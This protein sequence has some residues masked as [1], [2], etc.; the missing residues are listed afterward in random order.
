MKNKIIYLGFIS[1]FLFACSKEAPAPVA[2]PPVQTPANTMTPSTPMPPATPEP[3]KPT[4]PVKDAPCDK[5]MKFFEEQIWQ[6]IL[7]LQCVGCHNASGTAQSTRLVLNHAD[8]LESYQA[9]KDVALEELAGTSLLLLKPTLLHPQGHVGGQLIA[10]DSGKY[11]ALESFV[12][13]VKTDECD[14]PEEKTDTPCTEVKPGERVLRRLTGREY[15]NTIKDLLGVDSSFG[16]DFVTDLVVNGFNNNAEALVISGLLADQLSEAATSIAQSAV[17]TNIL[18]CTEQTETC[19]RQ[20]MTEFGER[21]YRQPLTTAQLNRHILLYR[22]GSDFEDGI[23]LVITAMLQSPHFLYRSELGTHVADGNYTLSP[24]EIA[25]QLSYFLTE[26]MPDA[27]LMQAARDNEL[28]TQA[29]IEA[30]ARRLL[31][32]QSAQAPIENFIGQWLH[33]DHLKTIPKDAITYPEFT[34]EIRAAMKNETK[35]F[36]NHVFDTGEGTLSELLTADYTFVNSQLGAFYDYSST[37][38]M[39]SFQRVEVQDGRQSGLLTQG[40]FLATHARPNSSSPIHRGLIV[41]ERILCQKLPPPPPG[42]NA[43]PPDLDPSLTTRERYK[44]HSDVQP[45][46]DCHRLIDPIG[47]AFEY[48][49]GIG[50]TRDD[51]S[52]H[53]IDAKGA[54]IDTPSSNGEFEG[55]QELGQHLAASPDAFDCFTKQYFRYAYGIDKNEE[56]ACLVDSLQ[57]DFAQSGGDIKALLISIASSPHITTRVGPVDTQPEP[58]PPE[59]EPLPE[60]DPPAQSSL[61]VQVRTDSDWGAGYCN[62]VTVTNNGAMDEDWVIELDIDGTI[63]NHW[64]AQASGTS[65]K[66]RFGGV[67]WNDIIT[68]GA[69]ANFGYCATR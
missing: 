16:K 62:N 2:T 56:R 5:E 37:G 8:R 31:D 33:L 47:F 64:N 66:V 58:E 29:Q 38:S 57:R 28:Q 3:M 17:L 15:D 42:V 35:R 61:D 19:A 60:P 48:F 49:D 25:S 67:H 40:S 41:R 20:F 21:A 50:R 7:S 65:G 27:Q 23:R 10:T 63:S 22:L 53:P 14:A 52:G 43:D 26:S 54:I 1:S 68:P 69:S 39:E 55:T 9:L 13:Q 6:P 12:A 24:Y 45:C 34:E 4:E 32:S 44:A 59:P 46:V 36:V 30:H 51:D 11:S 18:P